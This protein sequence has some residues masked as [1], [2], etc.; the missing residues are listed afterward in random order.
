MKKVL[1]VRVLLLVAIVVLAGDSV[2]ACLCKSQSPS[3]SFA[4]AKATASMIFVGQAIEVE[5]GSKNGQFH[6]WRIRL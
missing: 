6:G 4:R 2:V 3:K 5:N 1:L